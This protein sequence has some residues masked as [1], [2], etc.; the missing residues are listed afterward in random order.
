MGLTNEEKG[1]PYVRKHCA[2]AGFGAACAHH[3]VAVGVIGT[4][5]R[6]PTR[7]GSGGAASAAGS[8]RHG[9]ETRGRIAG[10]LNRPHRG[11]GRGRAWV[12]NLRSATRKYGKARRPGKTRTSDSAPRTAERV[13]SVTLGGSQSCGGSSAAAPG[14]KYCF[15]A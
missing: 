14:R 3:L 5:G 11:Q 2:F 13:E 4:S 9:R 10:Y 15:A 1:K 12:P 6:V 8:N 7:F